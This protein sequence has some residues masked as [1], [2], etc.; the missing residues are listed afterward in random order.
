MIKTGL[1]ILE[2]TEED[3][4]WYGTVYM[5]SRSGGIAYVSRMYDN[6]ISARNWCAEILIKHCDMSALDARR[7]VVEQNPVT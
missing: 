1:K 5:S 2:G 3:P 6:R 4:T 7:L